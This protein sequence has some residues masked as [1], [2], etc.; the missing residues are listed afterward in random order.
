MEQWSGGLRVVV[1]PGPISNPEVKRDIADGSASIGHA[2]VGRRQSLTAPWLIQSR[3]GFLLP[4]SFLQKY[5]PWKKVN[6][7]LEK[8]KGSGYW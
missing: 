4:R 7:L 5:A 2:R 8:L 6:V 1:P 3:G